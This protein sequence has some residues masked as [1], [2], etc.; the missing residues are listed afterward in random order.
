VFCNI[1]QTTRI[2]YASEDLLAFSDIA[3]A[4][5]I[6][7]LIIPRQ[8]IESAKHLKASHLPLLLNMRR[9]ALETLLPSA[10]VN[11]MDETQFKLGFHLP[12]FTTVPHLHLHVLTMPFKPL[13]AWKYRWSGN[14]KPLDV[15]IS[16]LQ[17]SD[18]EQRLL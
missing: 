17:D 12:P 1:E 6:H 16:E 11:T 13:R 5:K 2:L 8:H 18:S 7:F 9:V 14:W 3:P 15:L 4:A 10:G